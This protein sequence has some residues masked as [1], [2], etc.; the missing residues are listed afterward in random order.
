MKPEDAA[1]LAA[2]VL[3][4]MDGFGGPWCVAGGWAL[5]LFLGHVTRP[6]GDVELA[7]F[8]RDQALLHSHLEGWT[9][10]VSVDGRREPWTHGEVLELPRHEIHAHP[11]DDHDTDVGDAIEF[12]LNERDEHRWVFRRDPA[13]ALPIEHAILDTTVGVPVLS[14][15]IVLLYKAKSPRPKDEDDFRHAHRA[16]AP[17]SREWLHDALVRS[18]PQHPWARTLRR[19]DAER[20]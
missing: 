9:F 7:V 6:H 18:D 4:L 1:E 2:R 8:R 5:D 10:L 19:A 12:L 14:P 13:I 17:A 15:E 11:P 3:P 16:L 20:R